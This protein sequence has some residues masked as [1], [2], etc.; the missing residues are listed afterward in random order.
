MGKLL[1][2]PDYPWKPPR[3]MMVTD[4]GRFETYRRICLSIS[5]FHPESWC[6]VWPIE[7]IIVGLISFMVSN[8]NTVGSLSTSINHRTKIAKESR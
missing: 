2:P 5:D 1:F 4:S 8:Q 7:S 6:P 3:I